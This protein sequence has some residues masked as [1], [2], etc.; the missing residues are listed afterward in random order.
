[1][2][3]IEKLKENK[4]LPIIR[5]SSKQEVIDIVK[6]LK[7][8]GLDMME[9]NIENPYIFE[10]IS[11]ISNEVTV[12]A[13]GIITSI[14]ANAAMLAG[15]K[16]IS[17]PIFQTN[18][19]KISKDKRL[20]FIA[21]TSTANEAYSAWKSRIPV[22]KIYPI[23]AM[24]GVSYLEN[25]LRPM[26]FLNV[27]PQGNVAL[28]EVSSYIK[29]GAVAVGVGRNLTKADSYSEITKRAKSLLEQLG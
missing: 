7:D 16:I 9:I 29:A 27:I 20:P 14:Q 10:A 15:A 22:V 23:T 17:S 1:M 25:L 4:V 5:S 6:A 11:E 12:C 8:G 24:G 3:L 19:V 26:P 28:S 18:L 21:G 13:G 2:N